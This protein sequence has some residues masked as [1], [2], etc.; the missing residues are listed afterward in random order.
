MK[1]AESKDQFKNR[2]SYWQAIISEQEASGLSRVDFCRKH[3]INYDTFGYW[4]RKLKDGPKKL[5]IPVKLKVEN[6]HEAKPKLLSTLIFKAGHSLQVYDKEAL[7][8]VLSKL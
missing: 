3:E 2:E 6:Q 1:A 7:L 5:L 4:F 8:L